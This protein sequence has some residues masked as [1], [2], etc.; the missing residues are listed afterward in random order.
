MTREPPVHPLATAAAPACAGP[1]VDMH[2][3]SW[4]VPFGACDSHAH[5]IGDG[6]E[7]PFV[8]S[9]S[10]TPPAATERQYMRMLDA[11]GMTHGVL[12][13]VSVHG[14]DNRLMLEAMRNHPRRLR[15]VAVAAPDISDA[16]LRDMHDAGVRGLRLNVSIGGGVGFDALETLA[17]RIAPMGWHLQLLTTPARLVEVAPRL[18]GLP[19]PVVIDHMALVPAADGIEHPAFKAML[20]LVKNGRTWVKISGAYRI[21]AQDR[22]WT[23]VDPLAR[24]LL[25]AAPDRMVWGSDWPHVHFSKRMMGTGETLEILGRWIP[26]RA[27]RKRVLVDNPTALYGF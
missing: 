23:D 8:S 4:Q 5:V 20:E 25:A 22:D 12:V 1:R 26:D 11:L 15:G 16:A 19:V 24:A 7:Y 6:Y 17:S 27:L 21:S 10:Y 9:R 18:P 13:Q 14:T 2:P 3:P